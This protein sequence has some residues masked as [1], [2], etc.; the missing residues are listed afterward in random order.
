MTAPFKCPDAAR[1]L[2]REA[3]CGTARFRN[4][5]AT[6][7]EPH[8]DAAR[9]TRGPRR[10][11]GLPMRLSDDLSGMP[12]SLPSGSIEAWNR[13][14]HGILSHSAT[15]GPDLNA[16][17]EPCPDFA[18]G[19]ALRG[20]SCL[21]LARSEMVPVAR[22]AHALAR[23]APSA[24]PRETAFVEALGDL[25]EVKLADLASCDVW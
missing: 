19:Q 24:T 16:V 3:R 22:E 21:L 13:V 14:I 4:E 11:K 7:G 12:T 9:A 2:A 20:L 10:M 1:S 6:A 25:F 17:L 5:W 8:S 18:L 23:A 15:T